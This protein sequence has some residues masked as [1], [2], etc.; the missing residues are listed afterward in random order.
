MEISCLETIQEELKKYNDS[1][2]Y[3]TLGNH[4]FYNFNRL[5]IYD[6]L[7]PS[8]IQNIC[9]VN[10]L[11]Y[12]F[13]PVAGYRCIVLDGYEISTIGAITP[14]YQQYAEDLIRARNH[15]YAAGNLFIYLFVLFF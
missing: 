10:R 8:Y 11:Y 9:P 1:N 5:Q 13:I 14:E 12:S 7:F 15:N 4:E 6:N 2:W 3:Y